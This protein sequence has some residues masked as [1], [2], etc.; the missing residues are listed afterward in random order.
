MPSLRFLLRLSVIAGGAALAVLTF[1][2]AYVWVF[3]LVVLYVALKG[4]KP[5]LWA[6]GTARWADWRD[7]CARGMIGATGGLP[8]GIIDG[9]ISRR[10][11]LRALF[12]RRLSSAQAV[13]LFLRSFRKNPP[14]IQ[15]QLTDLVHCAVFAPSGAGKNVSIAEPLLLTSCENFFV[16]DIKGENARIT[17]EHR[18]R[19]FGH[20]IVLLDPFRLVTPAPASFNVLDTI[21]PKDP[22]CFDQCKAIADSIADKEPN[23]KEPHWRQKAVTYIGGTIAGVIHLLPPDRR[24][25]QEVVEILSDKPLLAQLIKR[26]Q[27]SAVHD[28]LLARLG[29][30]MSICTDRELDGVLSTAHRFLSFLSTPAVVESTRTTSGFDPA[31]LDGRVT[32]YLILPAKYMRS[33]AGLM[34]LWT[35]AI[36]QMA[37]VRGVGNPRPLNVL[38]DECAQLGH[39]EQIEDMLTI[40]RGYGIK[41]TLIFQSMAQLKQAFPDGRDGVLLSNTTQIFFAINDPATAEYVSSRLGEQTICV[42][43]GGTSTSHSHQSSPQGSGSTSTS[44]NENWQQ[45]GRKLMQPAELMTCDPRI[46]FV[47]HSGMPPLVTWLIRY[48]EQAFQGNFDIGFVRAACETLCLFLCAALF[49]VAA[50]ATALAGK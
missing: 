17:A 32:G 21:D 45:M 50:V 33:H 16:T 29:N 6:H 27:V 2:V 49:A 20:K 40:G 26:M 13:Q 11:G 28:G 4:H 47:F 48:Y 5:A 44:T 38:L 34:R 42:T 8:L 36:M 1:T 37:V 41:L 3:S 12:D 22:E 10:D 25:L 30:E 35:T 19:I 23:S 39:S 15:V 31:D 7:C 46:A 9:T 18:A 24:S 14:P 43:S